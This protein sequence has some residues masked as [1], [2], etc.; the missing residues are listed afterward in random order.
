MK[1][2]NYITSHPFYRFLLI[3]AANSLITYVIY[4]TGAMF[5]SYLLAYSLSYAAGIVISYYLNS[6]FVFPS[7]ISLIKA[8]SFS[9][10]YIG[11]YLLGIG[12]LFIFVNTWGINKFFAPLCVICTT[13]PFTY[14]MT[15]YVLTNREV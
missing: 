10:T 14:F 7:A 5:F 12:L 6:R 15:K 2:I 11:Q 9:L 13:I 4:I 1:S 8:F 3:G